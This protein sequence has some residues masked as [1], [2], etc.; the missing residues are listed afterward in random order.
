MLIK[1]FTILICQ[2][3]LSVHLSQ[4]N[5][6]NSSVHLPNFT[7]K[8]TDLKNE[9]KQHQISSLS[10]PINSTKIT[11]ITQT[12][13]SI[14]FETTKRH[15]TLNISKVD[16]QSNE[17]KFGDKTT[18]QVNKGTIK[19]RSEPRRS[20][21]FKLNTV[22]SLLS[23]YINSNFKHEKNETLDDYNFQFKIVSIQTQNNSETILKLDNLHRMVKNVELLLKF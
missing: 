8:N 3:V 1:V 5:I 15:K 11:N 9:T 17:T 2:F 21:F 10:L 22:D 23:L 13:E 6:S 7:F 14:T 18:I 16:F 19:S 12:N 20:K 4:H